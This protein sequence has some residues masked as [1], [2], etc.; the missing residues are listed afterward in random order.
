MFDGIAALCPEISFYVLKALSQRVK[1]SDCAQELMERF[2][3]LLGQNMWLYNYFQIMSDE[4]TT[5]KF[6]MLSSQLSS[7]Q[8][9]Q[10]EINV[11]EDE[12]PEISWEDKTDQMRL[13]AARYV[14]RK[15]L[16]ARDF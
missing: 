4:E 9:S 10:T 12:R 2:R 14:M 5:Q 6:G 1:D 11:A 7:L 3:A 8:A 13:V 15:A 16:D